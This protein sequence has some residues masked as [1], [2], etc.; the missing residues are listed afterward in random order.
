MIKPEG[1]PAAYSRELKIVVVL[2]V[3]SSIGISL[4][5]LTAKFANDVA[6]VLKLTYWSTV[7]LSASESAWTIPA[8][9]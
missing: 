2:K 1:I 5:Y 3:A 6:Y 8:W 4:E 9:V 7:L